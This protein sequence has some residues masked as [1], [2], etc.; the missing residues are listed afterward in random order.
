[1]LKDP[2]EDGVYR[3]TVNDELHEFEEN[4]EWKDEFEVEDED[5]D[6]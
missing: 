5:E 1:M 4:I 3:D 6:L 2:P